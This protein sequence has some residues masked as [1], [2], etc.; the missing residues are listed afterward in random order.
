[1]ARTKKLP[2]EILLHGIIVADKDVPTKDFI[3]RKHLT[4]WQCLEAL[5]NS[6][7]VVSVAV[8]SIVVTATVLSICLFSIGAVGVLVDPNVH[9]EC[10]DI[11]IVSFGVHLVHV[12]GHV[13]ERVLHGSL[14]HFEIVHLKVQVHE[15]KVEVVHPTITMVVGHLD[16]R[17]SVHPA[18]VEI[19]HPLTLC[20][21]DLGELG[22]HER[23]LTVLHQRRLAPELISQM[24]Q[25]VH[26]CLVQLNLSTY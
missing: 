23:P 22:R 5:V 11:G 25:V 17:N 24:P 13:A 7:V 26:S 9:L 3:P 8:A 16:I 18:V 12:V 19:I 21:G 10:I 2:L 15:A 1:M 14:I 4:R 20:P 6:R